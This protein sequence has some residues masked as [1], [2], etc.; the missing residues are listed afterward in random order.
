MTIGALT[1]PL[2][3]SSLNAQPGL[4]ALAVAQPADAGGQ[5]LEGDALLGHR[6]PAAQVVVV[7]EELED[8]PGRCAAMSFGSP[9]QRHPAE[10]ALALAE[11]RPDVGGHEAGEVEG[12]VVAALA[13]LVADGVAVVED[14]GAARP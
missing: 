3:T 11:Q 13:R 8:A 10:R 7:G 6:D 9:R 1:S 5:A 14:L 4:V 12:A 2:A